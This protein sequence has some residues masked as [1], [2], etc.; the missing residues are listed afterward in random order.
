MRYSLL[1]V[2]VAAFLMLAGSVSESQTVADDV[3]T[4]KDASGDQA[5]A[6]CARAISSG[7]LHGYDLVIEYNNR[8][9]AYSAKGDYDRGIADYTEAIRL[10][11]KDAVPY[12]NVAAR[13]GK[14]ATTTAPSPTTRRRSGL[15]PNTPPPTTTAAPRTAPRPTTIAPL[16]TSA[17]QSGSIPNTPPP[18]PSTGASCT[19]LRATPTAPSPTTPRRFDPKDAVAYNSRCRARTL[20]GRDLAR[21]LDD[22]NESLRL[23]PGDGYTLNSRGLVQLKLGAFEHA[24]A[25]YGAAAAKNPTDANSLYGRGIA[26][27]KSGDRTGGDAD[28]AAAKAINPDIADVYVS[29][30]V[31]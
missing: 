29:Y 22:C 18:T 16:R 6:A 20:A 7:R 4:C 9:N 8:G 10:G 13:I 21:A 19:T 11:P 2:G 24:I 30:G 12:K 15:I 31:T 14:R 26:K 3:A 23:Q 17:R 27:L 28:I 1:M 25:D 5:I